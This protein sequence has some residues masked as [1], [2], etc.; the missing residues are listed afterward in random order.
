MPSA[1]KWKPPCDARHGRSQRAS[2]TAPSAVPG[3]GEAETGAGRRHEHVGA[4]WGQRGAA[5]RR[6][7]SS[8]LPHRRGAEHRL[9]ARQAAGVVRW[10]R[11]RSRGTDRSAGGCADWHPCADRSCAR[12]WW[13]GRR[14]GSASAVCVMAKPWTTVAWALGSRDRTTLPLLLPESEMG[15]PHHPSVPEHP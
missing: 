2:P 6:T 13:S 5:R 15:W 4:T 14:G 10:R 11:G 9:A 1:V 7:C 3:R 8:A 12:L